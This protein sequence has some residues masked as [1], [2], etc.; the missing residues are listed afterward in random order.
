MI[1]I[2]GAREHNL[3]GV[4]LDLAPGTL[5]VFVGRSGS[6]KSSLAFDTVHAEGQRRY[7]EALVGRERGASSLARPDVDLV[8]GLPP[9][10][11][12]DQR[13][14][15]PSTRSTVATSTDVAALLRV[16]VARAGTQHCPSCGEPVVPRTHDEIVAELLRDEGRL[17]LDAPVRRGGSA[18]A[19]AFMDEVA[20]LGFSRMRIDGE[21]RRIEEIAPHQLPE[22]VRIV[23]DRIRV[24][25]DKLGRLQDAVRT[26]ARVGRG[27]LIAHRSG[28]DTRFVDR[29]Y[30][31][32]CDRSLP[33]LEP[34]L[35]SW[36][37]AGACKTCD[38]RGVV[39]ERTCEDCGGT[40]LCEEARAV[41]YAGRDL[42]GW[43]DCSAGELAR[44]ASAF[45]RTEITGPVLDELVQRLG[46]LDEVGLGTVS[47]HAP[48]ADLSA[49]ERQRLRIARHVGGALSGV[50]YV[51]DEPAAAL[52]DGEVERVVGLLRKLVDAGN[53]VLVV[54]HHPVVI[55]A[56]DRVVEFG[57]GAGQ[58]G[59]RIVFDGSV[60]ALRVAET[61]TGA[62]FAG[63]AALPASRGRAPSGRL[64]VDGRELPLG[65]VLAVTGP[66]GS[67]K[68]RLLE[69]A[70]TAAAEAE[71]VSRVVHADQRSV[72]RSPRSNAATYTGLW[73]VLRPLL[74]S[75]REGRVRGF[76]A[77][78]FSLNTNGGRCEACKGS[79]LRR[80]TL[81]L[82]PDVFT[83]C[84]VCDGRRFAADV[85]EVRWKGLSPD[86][87]LAGSPSELLPVLAGHPDLERFLRALVD[88]GLG[89]LP[90]G[91][92][93][94]TLS[95]G[96][97]QRLKLAR[98]L[99]RATKR[100]AE[101]TVLVLDDPSSGLHPEDVRV[102]VGLL[103]QLVDAG[104]TVWMATHHRGLVGWADRE[105]AL[106][107]R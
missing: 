75:T 44:E 21:T 69:L 84:P 65:A 14:S 31:P 9:T 62:W 16:L 48:V 2:R 93:G 53:T 86:E 36:Y 10:I 64:R 15:G 77:S 47:L 81:N 107:A 95:G 71:G 4:D 79:G 52:D 51:V 24:S 41:R 38:G 40:R 97:A 106:P 98:E 50:V 3:R 100:G 73:D 37:G 58:Q 46:V 45:A 83:R 35:L 104:A 23:V 20:G 80:V 54:E 34:E 29:P 26:A 78:Q 74:A 32:S 91:Q 90:L 99:A 27:V 43:L 63:R 89:Y 11:G 30:C 101:G 8:E 18:E 33:P 92:P 88:V 17:E 49:G 57:P 61:T 66:N 42:L 70:A 72:P 60:D 5:T 7:L 28:V 12:L 22:V 85:L 102:L 68:S 6:G 19:R 55:A 67:G 59:G 13:G 96:E 25:A 56:A 103:D 39:D 105:L 87:L 82:L 94:H 76:S 1:R